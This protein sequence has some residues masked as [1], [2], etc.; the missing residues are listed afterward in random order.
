MTSF[1]RGFMRYC[2]RRNECSEKQEKGAEKVTFACLFK[3]EERNE[4]IL[5]DD[6]RSR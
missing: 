1:L 2:T 4:N 5:A 6:L 3:I